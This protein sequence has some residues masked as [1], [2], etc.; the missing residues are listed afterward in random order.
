M[1]TP[2]AA[3]DTDPPADPPEIPGQIAIDDVADA[4]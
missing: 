1:T 2:V 4:P 3:L